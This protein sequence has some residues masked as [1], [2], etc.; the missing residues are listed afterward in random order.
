MKK[1]LESRL[2]ILIIIVC[3]IFFI[4]AVRLVQFQIVDG[5]EYYS[6]SNSS[7]RIN[8]SVTAA[9]G[10][11][12]DT[13]GVS[14]AGGQTVFDVTLNKAYMPDGMLN[15]RITQ[16]VEILWRQGETINDILPITYSEP[17]EFI[18]GKDTEISRLRERVKVAVYATADDA[19]GKLIERYDLDEVPQEYRRAVAGIRYTMEREGY[20]NSYPFDVAKDVSV[21]TATIIKEKSRT[22]TGVE[23]TESS[24][25]SYLDGT[26]LPHILG[27]VGPIYAEEYEQLKAQGY[28]LNDILGKSGLEK[29][30][31]SYLK[32][33]DGIVQIEKN[34]YGEITDMEVIQQPQPGNTLKLTIDAHLQQKANEVLENFVNTLHTKSAGWGKECDGAS[35][36]V[37]DVKTGAVLAICNYPSYDLNLYSSNYSTYASNTAKPL[38]NRSVQGVYRPGSTFKLNVAIAAL[39]TGLIDENFTYTCHGYYDYYSTSQWGGTLPGCAG[40]TAHGTINVRQAIRVS[41]NCFFYD[42]GRRLGIDTIN[43]SAHNLGLGVYTGL[44]I[45]ERLGVLSSPENTDL[46]GGTWQAGNVIQASIGQLDTMLTTV[47]LATYA[48]TIANKGVRYSTHIVDSITSYDGSEVIYETPITVLSETENTNNAFDIV[49]EGMIK[50]SNESYAS[51]YLKDLPFSVASKTGTA[52]VAGGYYNAVM[53]AYAPVEDPEIA[54]AVVAEKGGNGYNIALAVRDLLL[55]YYE[56]KDARA[57]DRLWDIGDYYQSNISVN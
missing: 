4:F 50:A 23:I 21:Q 11:I 41:C 48:S 16:V 45:N 30:Y 36:V 38:F 35:M 20:S 7:T 49:E 3:A 5:E 52:Q 13:Y 39:Q 54:I 18:D 19:M 51:Q 24:K 42:L 46:M 17:Y 56:V 28:G 29:A 6:K 32:G 26:L 14:L 57:N 53:V 27:T 22:L 40:G 37:L 31:E 25:R 10:D 1:V 2:N 44:E 43:E 12:T 34:M 55:A 9:R 15:Q 47:Q 33:E 8:Q